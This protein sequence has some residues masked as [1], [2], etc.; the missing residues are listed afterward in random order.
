MRGNSWRRV[1]TKRRPCRE[2][3]N[4][5]RVPGGVVMLVDKADYGRPT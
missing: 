2:A 3:R 4:P 5:H 1:E